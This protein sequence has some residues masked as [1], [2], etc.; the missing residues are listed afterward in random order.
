MRMF[1]RH[2]ARAFSLIEVMIATALMSVI[3]IGLLM[4]FGQT[5]RAFRLGV[6]QVDVMESGRA[7]LEMMARE[8][9]QAAP[10]MA[11][12][13]LVLDTAGVNLIVRTNGV[14][15]LIQNLPGGD[16]VRSFTRT[17]HQQDIVF[18]VR[19]GQQWRGV[20]FAVL[21]NNPVGALCRVEWSA[22]ALAPEDV[23]L[24]GA[25]TA[26]RIDYF[27]AANIVTNTVMDGVVH[28]RFRL[29]D[30]LG[31]IIEPFPLG[32]A[33]YSNLL[34]AVFYEPDGALARHIYY[35]DALPAHVEIELG[36]LERRAVERARALP[37]ATADQFLANRANQVHIFRQRVPLRHADPA[38]FQ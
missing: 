10:S 35:T 22:S 25:A 27:R 16:A 26:A 32:G 21:G 4:M 29:Y 34:A 12:P 33:P 18:L 13:G 38:T 19:D 8:I 28:L 24:L 5:Q 7:A 9:E 6:T 31:R 2:A 20:G 15:P 37:P 11:P 14:L 23:S 1:P 3:V 17:N 36:V 30:H